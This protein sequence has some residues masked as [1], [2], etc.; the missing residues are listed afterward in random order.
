MIKE[1]VCFD[2]NYFLKQIW[3]TILSFIAF[4]LQ[5]NFITVS[6]TFENAISFCQYLFFRTPTNRR[7][8]QS[9]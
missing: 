3:I 9:K 2:T 1:K 6:R 4:G 5:L 8:I 7:V